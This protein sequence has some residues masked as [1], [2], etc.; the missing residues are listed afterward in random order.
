MYNRRFFAFIDLFLFLIKART[1]QS[2]KEEERRTPKLLAG[3]QE[4]RQGVKNLN[5]SKKLKCFFSGYLFILALM[6]KK[7]NNYKKS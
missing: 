3:Q 5:S 4:S 1:T 6:N 2:L 7:I